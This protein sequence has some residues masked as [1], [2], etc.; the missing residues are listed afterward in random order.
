ML[1]ES[2]SEILKSRRKE[3]GYSVKDVVSLLKE[4]GVDISEKTLYGWESGHRQ[5]DADTF[6]IIC[7]LYEINDLMSLGS[8]SKIQSSLSNDEQEL[9][10]DYRNLTPNGQEK[11][12]EYVKDLLSNPKYIKTPMTDFKIIRQRAEA[13]QAAFDAKNQHVP[14]KK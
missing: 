3:L 7:R 8:E 11:T 14:T 13:F 12:T 9:L 6:L 5:P 2:I 1:K 10:T 4:N